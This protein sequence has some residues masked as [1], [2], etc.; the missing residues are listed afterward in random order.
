MDPW[1]QAWEITNR[2]G[3]Y[4]NQ[5]YV[6]GVNCC[7]LVRNESRSCF[8]NSMIL[9]P[10]GTV[11]TQLGPNPGILKADLYPG[12]IDRIHEQAVHS[13]P[14]Y[15]FRHRG[16]SCPDLEGAGAERLGYEAYREEEG[17]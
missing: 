15:S 8:G 2:A 6:V 4:F 13:A 17:K 11:I 7:G 10:D 1:A 9:N 16:G 12:I 3:A 5:V 14:M